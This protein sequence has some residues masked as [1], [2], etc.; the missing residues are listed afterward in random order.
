M[1]NARASAVLDAYTASEQ[2]I[3]ER[4]ETAVLERVTG[5]GDWYNHDAVTALATQ[6]T[7]LVESGQRNE[8]ALTDAYLQRIIAETIGT[9]VG[10]TA[11]VDPAI[12]RQGTT[13]V[14]AYTRL[15]NQYRW[16]ISL[17]IAASAAASAAVNRARTMAKTD[18]RMAARAQAQKTLSNKG[19][20]LYRR[21]I[22]PELSP[23]GVC[24]ICLA[25][26]DRIYFV[27]DLLPIHNGC[28]CAVM[29][30][31]NGKD[32]GRFLTRGDLDR[33]YADAGDSTERWALFNQRYE[34]TEHGEIGPMLVDPKHHFRGPDEVPMALE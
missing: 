18:L 15:A 14:G 11:L 1:D 33:L 29:P 17:G 34:I 6:L 2:L 10:S 16:Q 32:P 21:V 23:K 8:T 28:K 7:A 5:F 12:L 4:V 13:H 27:G 19:V 22:R 31:I 24:G 30:I 25:A 26:S 20:K 3:A 9:E